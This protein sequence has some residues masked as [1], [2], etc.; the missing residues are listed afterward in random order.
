MKTF[1]HIVLAMAA[2]LTLSCAKEVQPERGGEMRTVQYGITVDAPTRTLG[3]GKTATHVWYALY[4]ADGS[5]VSECAAPAKIDADRKAI[6]PVTMA[7]DQDYKV[8]FLA[9]YYEGTTP[10][11]TVDA[12][13]KTVSMPT[14]AQ[15]NSDKYD[16]FYGVDEVVDFQGAQ[17]TNVEL[18]RAVAMVNFI[19]N[20]E[21]WNAA[22]AEGNTP[23]HSS[24]EL[25]GVSA[26]FNLLTGIP[27]E[28]TT[29]IQFAKAQ[30][31]EAK[32]L[33]AVFSLPGRGIEATINLYTSDD[34]NAAPVKTLTVS[35]ITV[36]ANKKTNIT[37]NIIGPSAS[38]NID[39]T[40]SQGYASQGTLNTS[41]SHRVMT[42]MIH[43]SF[44]VEVN[45]GY[46][47]RAVYTYP[48]AEVTSNY[49]CVLAN[50][51]D[52]TQID[53]FNEGRYAVITFAKASDPNASI[54]PSEDII[55]SLTKYPIDLP[56][57][58]QDCPHINSAV[59]FGDSIMHGVYSY[60]ET[61]GDKTLRKNGFDS[62]SNTHLRIP[63]YFGLLAGATVT[64]NAKRG[65]GWI[66]DTRNW[67][68]ALEM[69]NDTD[70]TKYD[71][72]AFCLGINDW[73]QGAE[74]GSLDTPGKT[75]GSISEGTVV[76]NMMACIDK[77]K[78]ANPSCTIVVY[79]PY[80][81]WGQVSN[82]GDYTSNT[83]YGDE[84]TNFALGATNKKGYTLQ[85]LIDTIDAV[86]RRYGIRHVPLSQSTVCTKE[87]VKDIMIDGLH[88]SREVRAQLALEILQK[89]GCCN[90]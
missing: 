2:L 37:G 16:L 53:V 59:F 35:N 20:D 87:N 14:Q 12:Q 46:V 40:L 90:M 41:A 15:A 66:T 80:I 57:P 7:K 58:P 54:S 25:S 43:G 76:A 86:C 30:I 5:L 55:K 74:L 79:S 24:I 42:N 9:M 72:A 48:T 19:S 28:T 84:S 50:C 56:Y 21:D 10:A 64:N 85:Q 38:E 60:Y 34:Q 49:T 89:A 81:S 68:N 75:G 11:Y 32:H 77:V 65:S 88:P 61:D 6:C 44:S 23:T 29:D 83:L 22:V 70:F 18:T 39:Y 62:D 71:F 45:P 47:I 4:R 13:S 36:E 26:G 33:G 67:G 17:S 51:T 82:G 73:I 52:R 78:A 69:V 1:K 27:S 3:D 8:V 31:P 63:D